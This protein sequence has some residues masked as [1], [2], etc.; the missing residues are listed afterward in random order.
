MSLNKDFFKTLFGIIYCPYLN[1]QYIIKKHI[2][3]NEFI[4]IQ[5]L[6]NLI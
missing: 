4:Y 6:H 5:F 2:F 1:I 3:K